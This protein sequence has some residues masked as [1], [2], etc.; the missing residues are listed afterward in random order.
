MNGD[1]D[2]APNSPG[3][4][5]GHKSAIPP[6]S[7]GRPSSSD[8]LFLKLLFVQ[9]MRRYFQKRGDEMCLLW[10]Y[11][12]TTFFMGLQLSELWESGKQGQPDRLALN[13]GVASAI[14]RHAPRLR[15]AS[16][17]S[18]ES[19]WQAKTTGTIPTIP[20]RTTCRPVRGWR[21]PLDKSP[22]SRHREGSGLPV[23]GMEKKN[24]QKQQT[25][26]NT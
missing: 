21:V 24:G 22:D 11:P 9:I 5:P 6:G 19:A 26:E 1:T 25:K 15:V 7:R 16:E 10:L 13:P 23:T 2:E 8:D 14:A 4:V 20:D 17:R 3:R 18:P 12:H